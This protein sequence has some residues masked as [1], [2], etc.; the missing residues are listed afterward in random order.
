ML[1]HGVIVRHEIRDVLWIWI[2][3][4]GGKDLV[5]L[6]NSSAVKR[7][8]AKHASAVKTGSIA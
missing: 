5:I 8:H 6:E 2:E 1:C 7:V 3:D 4:S